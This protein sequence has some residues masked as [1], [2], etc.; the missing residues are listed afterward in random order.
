MRALTSAV[1]LGLLLLCDPTLLAQEIEVTAD[2]ARV[3]VGDPVTIRIRATLG[4]GVQL[5]DSVPRPADT[6]PTGMR[7]LSADSLLAGSRGTL[8]SRLHVAFFQPGETTVPSFVL[9]YRRAPDAPA[10]TLRSRPL[11]IVVANVLPP[12]SQPLKDIRD[13]ALPPPAAR[14]P[15]WLVPLALLAGLIVGYVIARR[16]RAGREAP[17]ADDVALAASEPPSAYELAVVRL[18]EVERARWAARGE[19][20]RHYELVGDVLR[21][22]LQEGESVRALER[23]SAEIVWSLPPV[24]SDDGMRDACREL[25][26]EADLVKFARYR[27][28]EPMADWFT[29]RARGLLER[30]HTASE[31]HRAEARR[32]AEAA[33]TEGS[34]LPE[35]ADSVEADGRPPASAGA[36]R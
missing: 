30:W 17:R 2:T 11:R 19:V 29:T 24:L 18:A 32:A 16:R 20:A 4:A 5:L 15:R 21:R 28:G 26:E 3:T 6:L 7:I 23:T 1:L 31:A 34:A 22:Y 13:L 33:L 35:E 36:A 12:G 27:P 10:D 8:A 25:L 14:L 9:A